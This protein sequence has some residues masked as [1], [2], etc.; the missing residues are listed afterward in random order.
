MWAF[1]NK[2]TQQLD[3]TFHT[4]LAN[5]PILWFSEIDGGFFLQLKTFPSFYLSLLNYF[6]T[7]AVMFMWLV[8]LAWEFCYL[9]F[10]G[11]AGFLF[12]FS[13]FMFSSDELNDAPR[14]RSF[15]AHRRLCSDG[16]YDKSDPG[17]ASAGHSLSGKQRARKA[18]QVDRESAARAPATALRLAASPDSQTLIPP[19]VH[20]HWPA[21][22]KLRV[23]RSAI[24]PSRPFL[25]S[26][27][28]F[29]FPSH[30]WG[31]PSARLQELTGLVLLRRST[32]RRLLACD[33]P[34]RR[35][36]RPATEAV[37]LPSLPLLFHSHRGGASA[38]SK[39]KRSAMIKAA[40]AGGNTPV[41]P[42]E[43]RETAPNRPEPNRP[44]T[45]P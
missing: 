28:A 12:F 14:V 37:A 20:R 34:A 16:F 7:N 33:W 22:E 1:K 19:L 13:F 26:L 32:R 6:L 31:G 29:P 38:A 25:A 23:I 11:S 41:W 39:R 36:Q 21:A 27:W 2:L 44:A 42:R 35:K 24:G 3:I 30:S 17:S 40:C 18:P 10:C 8:Y 45:P 9:W 43:S 15:P 4:Y 5:N